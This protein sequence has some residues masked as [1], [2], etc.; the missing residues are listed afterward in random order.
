VQLVLSLA[1]DMQQLLSSTYQCSRNNKQMAELL[2][3]LLL[4]VHSHQVSCKSEVARVTGWHC[5]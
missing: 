3:L 2:L 5:Q 4:V 1:G